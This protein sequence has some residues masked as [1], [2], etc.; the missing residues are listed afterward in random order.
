MLYS[1]P[2]GVDIL[3]EYESIFMLYIYAMIADRYC[4]FENRYGGEKCVIRHVRIMI[5]EPNTCINSI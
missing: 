5:Q 3:T 1:T 2:Y 4:P